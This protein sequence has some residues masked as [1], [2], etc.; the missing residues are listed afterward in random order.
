MVQRRV[1][2]PAGALTSASSG[3][4]T[5]VYGKEVPGSS[6]GKVSVPAYVAGSNTVPAASVYGLVAWLT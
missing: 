5:G 2:E 6:V 4:I 1:V 3:S